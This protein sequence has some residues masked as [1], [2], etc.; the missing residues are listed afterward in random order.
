MPPKHPTSANHGVPLQ[1]FR[2]RD[3]LRCWRCT[4]DGSDLEELATKMLDSMPTYP[5]LVYM[6]EVKVRPLP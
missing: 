3:P 1:G 6:R 5:G 4:G 2:A